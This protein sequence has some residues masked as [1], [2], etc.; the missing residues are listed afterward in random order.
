MC[1]RDSYRAARD[2][3]I[4]VNVD[5]AAGGVA[6]QACGF[7]RVAGGCDLAAGD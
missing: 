5:P 7:R 1:I 3:D 2:G 6:D 4:A